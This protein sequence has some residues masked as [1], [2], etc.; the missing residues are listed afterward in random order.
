MPPY[1]Q[2]ETISMGNTM[3]KSDKAKLKAMAAELAKN[4][5]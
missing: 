3:D 2:K 5:K 4:I 1:P